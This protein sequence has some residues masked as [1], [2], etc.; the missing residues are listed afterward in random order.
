MACP[1]CDSEDIVFHN[2]F[3]AIDIFNSGNYFYEIVYC[4]DCGEELK[5]P[6]EACSRGQDG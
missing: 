2:G 3:W 4:P 6:S 1:N 5:T